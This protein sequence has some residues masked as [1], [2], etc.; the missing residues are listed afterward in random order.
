MNNLD[1][2]PCPFCNGTVIFEKIFPYEIYRGRCEKCTMEFKYEHKEE[3]LTEEF[4][5]YGTK[6]THTYPEKKQL[7]LPFE[8]AWNSRA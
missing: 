8:D 6:I 7:N 5:T 4:F 2:K 1:L 3:L